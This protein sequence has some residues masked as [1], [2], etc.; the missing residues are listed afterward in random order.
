MIHV[1]IL[2]FSGNKPLLTKIIDLMNDRQNQYSF[3]YLPK[4]KIKDDYI[5]IDVA[6]DKTLKSGKNESYK[7]GIF[8]TTF[9][10]N[11]F[12]MTRWRIKTSVI[13]I[14]D[15]NYLS[16]L[17]L[18]SYLVMEIAEN[19]H[20]QL[21]EQDDYSFSHELPIGCIHDMCSYKP[22]INLKILTAYICPACKELIKDSLTEM[23]IDAYEKLL[24][25][26]RDFAFGKAKA[27][28]IQKDNIIF[29]IAYKLRQIQHV[30]NV[31]DKFTLLI[32]FV[33]LQ[34]RLVCYLLYIRLKDIGCDYVPNFLR[35]LPSMGDWVSDM[36]NLNVEYEKTKDTFFSNFDVI[37]IASA[38]RII[39]KNKL[40][41]L[42]NEFIGHG[43]T[44]PVYTIQKAFNDNFPIVISIFKAL[45]SVF[46]K[47]MIIATNSH[48]DSS[49]EVY[50]IDSYILSDDNSFFKSGSFEFLSNN[51]KYINK[52]CTENEILYFSNDESQLVSLSPYLYYR[53]CPLCNHPRMLIL[54]SADNYIDI[55]IGHR[56]KLTDC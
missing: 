31:Q 24:N 33:D 6:F 47:K 11:W 3:K 32:N 18:E 55:Q 56:T 1:F 15:W 22:D 26:S 54:D 43:Y 8:N 38:Y 23:Q 9:D 42:R 14:A 40:V 44:Q 50:I 19:F 25:L 12:S 28:D 4:N 13:T 46:S 51:Q 36:K 5:D 37:N 21:I 35:K 41:N 45:K 30:M 29:P 16:H 39:N 49:K 52:I 48:F 34:A 27:I 7:I 10:N 2:D 20:E 53:V 17:P